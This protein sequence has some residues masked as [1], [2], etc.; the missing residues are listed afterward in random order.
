MTPDDDQAATARFGYLLLNQAERAPG[1]EPPMTTHW[2]SL[3]ASLALIKLINYA[4]SSRA[5]SELKNSRFSNDL[6]FSRSSWNGVE[7]P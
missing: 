5:Y 3:G 4:M 6:A 7:F 2:Y 1:Y